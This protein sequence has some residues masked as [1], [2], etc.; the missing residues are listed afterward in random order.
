MGLS[1]SVDIN[2]RLLT[3][4]RNFSH[5]STASSTEGTAVVPDCL[6]NEGPTSSRHSSDEANACQSLYALTKDGI[7]SGHLTSRLK[8]RM[9]R[10]ALSEDT[11]LHCETGVQS[12]LLH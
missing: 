7:R 2:P 11:S 5:R 4:C 8:L 9:T 10:M 3:S 6:V 12:K 1:I